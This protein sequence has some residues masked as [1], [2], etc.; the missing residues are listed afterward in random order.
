VNIDLKKKEIRKSYFSI[1]GLI[2]ISI[3]G[4]AGLLMIYFSGIFA[5]EDSNMLY[6]C[7]S[8]NGMLIIFGVFFFA[9]SL[10][11]WILFFLNNIL[12]PKKEILYLNKTDD[13]E[14]FFLN[15]KGKSFSYNMNHN[16]LEEN[17]YYL[18][19]KTHNY[20]Y[21]ILEKTN[22]N[23]IPK[24][25]KSY[26]L[27]Y[28]SPMGNFEN[29]FLLPIVYVILLPGVLSFFMSKGYQKIYGVIFSIVPLYAII[30]DLIYK[31]KLKQ[32][33]TKKIDE[34]N[35]VKSYEIMRNSITIIV[36]SIMIGILLNIFFQLSD[37]IS[38]IIFSP[39]LGCGLCTFGLVISRVFKNY[40]LEKLFYKGYVIIFL[41][42]WF[43]F[44][45]FWTIGIISIKGNYMYALFSIPFWIFGILAFYKY[46]IKKK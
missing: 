38:I 17:S 2:I 10:Y 16:A 24:E 7:I 15:K 31:I 37:F 21:K 28:Y 27:N 29:I 6:E 34:T 14:A 12:P 13:G 46:I 26:W 36:V 9:V 8:K 19:L 11:V 20:I 42:Y 39:F 3:L 25:K 1:D 5:I 22:A 4:T 40:Q 30:Y 33:G 45:S 43:G 18:V 32:S 23:W 35:F 41:I 44:L